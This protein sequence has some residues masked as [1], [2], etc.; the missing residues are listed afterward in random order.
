MKGS[1]WNSLGN[2]LNR[3]IEDAIHRG[4]FGR[5]SETIDNT[6]RSAFENLSGEGFHANDGWDFDLSGDDAQERRAHAEQKAPE[7]DAGAQPVRAKYESVPDVALSNRALFVGSG[8]RAGSAVG[9]LAGGGVSAVIGFIFLMI[10]AAGSA[11]GLASL[12]VGF[13]VA[14]LM[15]LAGGVVL[16]ILGVNGLK[17]SKRFEQH[18][19]S[20]DGE[21]Y[22]DIKK[23][24]L[25][26]HRSETD[27]LK[28]I[29]KMLRKGWFIQGHLDKSESCLMVTN[30]SYEQYLEALK[31]A[32]LREEENKRRREAE[33][34][35][36]GGLTEEVKAILKKGNEYIDSIRK[37]NDAI[38]GE[39]ISEKIYRM[40]LLVRR[41]F[42]Q[43]EAH[44]ENADDLDRLMGYYLP[45]TIKLLNAYEELDGQPVQGDNILNSKKEIEDTLDT[46][47]AAYARMLDN[48]FRDT[49]W[50]ISSDISV[51]QTLLAQEGLTE[52][53][54]AGNEKK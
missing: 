1:D 24:S 40:E 48:L 37:S 7:H 45:M 49:A 10:F 42:Q 23:L 4:N 14:G 6:V 26:C 8:R 11:I 30:D 53:G 12:G 46:L 28:E 17:L 50:D 43:T 9:M 20:M 15:L 44:P 41:I 36:T 54:I 31:N 47:N 16:L 29:K 39:K 35:R 2:D 52:D 34:A 51:L 5:L 33:N 27:V 19:R 3:I 18:I 22:V 13:L 32:R 21:A 25:Y 38:P